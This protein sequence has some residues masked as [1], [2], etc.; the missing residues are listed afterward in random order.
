[1]WHKSK[2]HSLRTHFTQ[3]SAVT[4]VSD[5]KVKVTCGVM[6]YKFQLV[7][8]NV[9]VLNIYEKSN[10]K[11]LHFSINLVISV[12]LNQLIPDDHTVKVETNPL[13]DD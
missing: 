6:I 10:D 5:M 12:M 8:Q 7:Y 2:L 1:M 4:V 13:V 9:F 3:E 11:L